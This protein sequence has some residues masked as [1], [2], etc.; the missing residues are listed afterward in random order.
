M[1]YAYL[2]LA[3]VQRSLGPARVEALRRVELAREAGPLLTATIR[4]APTPQ[5]VTG[6]RL[7][8]APGWYRFRLNDVSPGGVTQA[9]ALY[10]RRAAW[11]ADSP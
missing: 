11:Q 1:I 5:T 9:P 2:P 3:D 10:L 6:P 4:R 7:A 8:L